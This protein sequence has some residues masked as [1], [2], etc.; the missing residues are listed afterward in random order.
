M[1]QYKPYN[2]ILVVIVAGIGDFIEAIP[3]VKSIRDSFPKADVTLLVSSKVYDYA[4]L[5]PYVN[6]VYSLPVSRG[7]GFALG[8]IESAGRYLKL[9]AELRKKIFDAAVNM[10][11][12]STWGGALRMALLFKSVRSGITFGRNTGGKGFFFNSK[13]K[14][15]D[16]DKFNQAHY[17]NLLTGSLTGNVVV[18][19]ALPWITAQDDKAVNDLFKTWGLDPSDRIMLIN[20]GSDRLTRRWLPDNFAKI[21]EYFADNNQ[22][23]PVFTGSAAETPVIE[24]IEKLTKVKTFSSAG[25]LGIGGLAAIIRRSKILFTTNSAAMHI[26]GR[27]GVPFVAAAGSG[28]PFR[29]RPEGDERKMSI[30]WKKC[31][32]NPCDNYKCNKN[33]YMECMKTI[34]A[35]EVI[36]AGKR[37]LNGNKP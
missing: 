21:I 37:L 7:R 22:F 12:I 31:G 16:S 36:A 10:Y 4:K 2:S 35:D 13:L 34:T 28:D 30:L 15:N 6:S 8:T 18:E 33:K 25:K 11:E 5:C 3:A 9:I 24:E 14:D 23:I 26:A 20:P 27:F 1:E 32:C 29:D 19:N 17:F